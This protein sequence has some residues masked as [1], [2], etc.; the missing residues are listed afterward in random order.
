[1]R[2]VHSAHYADANTVSTR[3]EVRQ[4][5]AVQATYGY[6]ANGNRTTV[7][8]VEVATYDAQD[9]LTTYNGT[10]YAYT[11]HGDL[12]SKTVG[13]Q[14]TG[15]RYD[16]FGNLRQVTQP[17]GTVIDYRIDGQHRRIGKQ[18]NGTPVQ[19]FLYQ[20]RLRPIAELHGQNQIVS[21]FVYADKANVP[22]YLIRGGNTYRILTDHLGSP[23]LVVNTAD[24]T[25][26][27]RLDY[28]P[29]GQ[30]ILDTNPGFQPFGYAGGL[31]DRDTGLVRF[32]ARDYDPET[33]RW[34]TK[35][36]IRFAGGDTNLYGYVLN[37]P[38]N[39]IDSDGQL[40]QQIAAAVV[41]IAAGKAIYDFIDA[42]SEGMRDAE[43]VKKAKRDDDEVMSNI[44][45]GKPI[46]KNYCPNA[47]SD[48]IKDL[49][50]SAADAALKGAQV[51]G[52]YAGGA[53][54]DPVPTF[55]D[56]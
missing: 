40:F 56:P 15:F 11:A 43:R 31:Y 3:A 5:G 49:T 45:A 21:R 10:S 1:M 7:N 24:G 14:V 13:G 55:K 34:T 27:Q 48:A 22:A 46:P 25:V 32:G 23:R 26:M 38:V 17:G 29:W 51:P 18:V 50:K 30:V 9:R 39:W 44:L 47:T 35:D 33:G 36:P 8:G 19:G 53:L 4:N 54:A 37:D 41:V 42:Y 16:G 28:D 20:D 6:D 52:T 2:A 12:T